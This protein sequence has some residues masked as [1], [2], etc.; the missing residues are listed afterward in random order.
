MSRTLIRQNLNSYSARLVSGQPVFSYQNV[1]E[2]AQRI[3]GFTCW[4]PV[5]RV[6]GGERTTPHAIIW[7]VPEAGELIPFKNLED[8]RQVQV[9]KQV[10]DAVALLQR[11]GKQ[12]A[13]DP[14][15]SRR[16]LGMVLQH[17]EVPADDFIYLLND[18]PVITGW[19]LSKEGPE[20]R[21]ETVGLNTVAGGHD[22]RSDRIVPEDPPPLPPCRK[23]L[24]AL[25]G[26]LVGLILSL[27]LFLFFCE[28]FDQVFGDLCPRLS[29]CKRELHRVETM[30]R[31]T[32][33]SLSESQR[34][35][36][37]YEKRLAD[38]GTSLG[39]KTK[40][41][42]EVQAQFK[43]QAEELRACRDNTANKKKTS[44]TEDAPDIGTPQRARIRVW[45]GTDW[46]Y[47]NGRTEIVWDGGRYVLWDGKTE[48]CWDGAKPVYCPKGNVPPPRKIT[49][50]VLEV[51][52]IQ[53]AVDPPD[54]TAKWRI[55]INDDAP[56]E[57]K[58]NPQ[59]FI[60]FDGSPHENTAVGASV[61]LG[62]SPL[63]SG[64]AFRARVIATDSRGQET[65]HELIFGGM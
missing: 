65:V 1:S 35:L 63:A 46:I 52:K 41:L 53:L 45:N 19:G 32:Q 5:G 30:L 14:V 56:Q 40:S 20:P 42:E 22:P 61:K 18:K 50:K 7:D 58:E 43:A 33:D 38:C 8:E 23:W 24:W 3:P 13:G 62:L 44:T 16:D 31:T 4:L 25:A 29:K 36:D 2:Y 47:W 21:V 26:G 9:R 11:E 39:T 54:P 15:K 51:S 17:L 55:K 27:A 28:Q 64:G 57:V 60:Y 10:Q 59:R 6:E 49:W 12:L 48:R 37:A 34:K